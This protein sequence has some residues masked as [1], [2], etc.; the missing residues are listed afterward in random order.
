MHM[1]NRPI[2]NSSAPIMPFSTDRNTVPPN[3]MQ[4]PAIIELIK[5]RTVFIIAASFYK[6]Y[7]IYSRMLCA[8][9]TTTGIVS[10][11]SMVCADTILAAKFSSW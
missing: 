4:T 7:A 9:Q 8:M 11:E 6:Y 10:A 2:V 3:A 1:V 5:T